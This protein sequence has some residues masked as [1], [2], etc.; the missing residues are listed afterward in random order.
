M[1]PA[2]LHLTE[3]Q[4]KKD[5]VQGITKP[6]PE[7]MTHEPVRPIAK[8]LPSELPAPVAHYTFKTPEGNRETAPVITRYYPKQILYPFGKVDRHI[9]ARLTRA[10]TIAEERA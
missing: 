10:A 9:D 1:V 2:K 4:S 8:S 6:E 3:R 7:V 5:S